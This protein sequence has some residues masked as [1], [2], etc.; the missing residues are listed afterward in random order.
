MFVAEQGQQVVGFVTGG[1][2]AHWSGD[3]D[4]YIGEL[5]V[6]A[7]SEGQGIGSD[8]L[9]VVQRW[10][11]QRGYARIVLETG[12]ANTRACAFYE[13]HGYSTEEVVLSRA[14]RT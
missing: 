7:G 5:A 9:A 12:A 11:T 14:L 2:R 6:A 8:L 4:A 13:R 10:A 1:S 3:Q